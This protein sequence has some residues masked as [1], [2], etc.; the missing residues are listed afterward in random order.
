MFHTLS[1]VF[2]L[3]LE[4]CLSHS[5][6]P[7]D[8]LLQQLLSV[9]QCLGSLPEDGGGLPVPSSCLCSSWILGYLASTLGVSVFWLSHEVDAVYIMQEKKRMGRGQQ[10]TTYPVTNFSQGDH[11]FCCVAQAHVVF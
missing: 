4:K 7:A 1:I 2:L 3:L 5:S 11:C 10:E 8:K 9:C 6:S